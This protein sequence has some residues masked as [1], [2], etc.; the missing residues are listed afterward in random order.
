MKDYY[1]HIYLWLK[2]NRPKYVLVL[3]NY[4]GGITEWLLEDVELLDDRTILLDGIRFKDYV[5]VVFG[6][7]S[8]KFYKF[9]EPGGKEEI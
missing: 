4:S 5:D 8:C 3:I 1:N 9:K 7:A 6:D 2:A